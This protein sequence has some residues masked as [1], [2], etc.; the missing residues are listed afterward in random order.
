[1]FGP[2]PIVLSLPARELPLAAITGSVFELDALSAVPLPADLR[3]AVELI[4]G[5][6]HGV[7]AP[8]RCVVRP[9]M[10]THGASLNWLRQKLGDATDH[11]CVSDG[12]SI[13]LIPHLRNHLFTYG[14][15][16]QRRQLEFKKL[17][18]RAPELL[19]QYD[20]QVNTFHRIAADGL[21]VEPAA[22][23]AMPSR[24]FAAAGVW[25]YGFYLN[26]HSAEDSAER[27]L[28]WGD[29]VAPPFADF[30]EI[31]YIPL[32]EC[33]MKD[34]GFQ[35]L[36]FETIEATYFEPKS[37]LLLRLPPGDDLT[38][39]MKWVVE[40]IRAVSLRL[41]QARSANIFLVGS[42]LPEDLLRQF[43]GRLSLVLHQSFE[44]WRYTPGVY[45]QANK[46]LYVLDGEWK[47]PTECAKKLLREAFGQMPRFLLPV[48]PPEAEWL[49]E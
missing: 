19:G 42:D 43:G 16:A 18:R 35:R 12:V 29:L 47:R 36:V 39:R 22:N 9:E 10:F 3:M 25:Y 48:R 28:D 34:G 44:Y 27:M 7:A 11:I 14:L 21:A 31:T 33:V 17:M 5:A 20:S 8:I 45:A 37:V 49:T 23:L 26:P 4:A 13:K 41:P 46:I 2:E 24:A 30:R 32:T 1:M 40:G 15:H 6:Y 38:V